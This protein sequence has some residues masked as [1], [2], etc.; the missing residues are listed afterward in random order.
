MKHCPHEILEKRRICALWILSLW[1]RFLWGH[2]CC[3]CA[4]RK[5]LIGQIPTGHGPAYPKP[6]LIRDPF[7]D[8]ECPRRG[9]STTGT[10]TLGTTPDTG[11]LFLRASQ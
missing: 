7:F 10:I 8:E 9:T 5:S 11:G 2:I 3:F 4:T 1:N 6:N